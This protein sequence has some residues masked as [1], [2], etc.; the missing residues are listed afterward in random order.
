MSSATAAPAVSKVSPEKQPPRPDR[1]EAFQRVASPEAI[2]RALEW[3]SKQQ[4][5]IVTLVLLLR[6][7]PE[8]IATL[9]RL[10]Q[11][12][13]VACRRSGTVPTSLST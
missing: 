5:R 10:G 11:T 7:S 2:A 6:M 12:T 9:R 8:L 4:H 13:R 3:L 1:L